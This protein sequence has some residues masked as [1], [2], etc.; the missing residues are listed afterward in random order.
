MYIFKHLKWFLFHFLSSYSIAHVCL[1]LEVQCYIQRQMFPGAKREKKTLFFF[2]LSHLQK[3]KLRA[4][5]PHDYL[6][7]W[8]LVYH[9][10]SW[11]LFGSPAF[12]PLPQTT[13][14]P[15]SVRANE[16][17]VCDRRSCKWNLYY[18]SGI[19]EALGLR[20]KAPTE[21]KLCVLLHCVFPKNK[22]TMNIRWEPTGFRIRMKDLYCVIL[23]VFYSIINS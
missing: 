22:H 23:V 9:T 21:Y 16:M 20:C 8:L 17:K 4:L 10:I 13:T 6:S 3:H 11:V 14:E 18:V 1:L 7:K 12:F 5:I 2:R 15:A 19:L